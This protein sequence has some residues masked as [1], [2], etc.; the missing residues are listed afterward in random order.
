MRIALYSPLP[1]ERSGIADYSF[2]LLDELRHHVDV[3]AVVGDAQLASARAPEGV[4]LVPR[5][6]VDGLDIDCNLYQMGNNPRYHRSFWARAFDEPGLLVLHDPSLADITAEMCGGADG[7]IFRA[8]VAYD[9]PEIG[10]DDVLPLVETGGGRHDLDRLRVLLARRI[11]ESNIRTLVHSTAMAREMRHRYAGADIRTIQLPAPVLH[12]PSGGRPRAD[13]EIVFGVFG[14]INYYKRVRPLVDAFVEVRA[15]HPLARMVVAGRADEHLLERELRAIAARPELAGALE[16]KTD[17]TRE[18]LEREMLRCDV[19]ISLRWPTA[20]EM[21]ATLMRTLGAGRPAIVSD[22]LQFRELD[23]RYCWRVTTDF[24][25]EHEHLVSLMSAAATDLDRCRSAGDAAREFVAAE[26]TYEVVAGHYVEHLEHCASRRS[27]SRAEHR[28][29]SLSAGRPLGINVLCPVDRSEVA[30]AARRTTEVLRA[31]G[32]DVVVV[33][34]AS[35]TATTGVGHLASWRDVPTSAGSRAAARTRRGGAPLRSAHARTGA[36]PAAHDERMSA[37]RSAVRALDP[38]DL[39][40]EGSGPHRVDLLFVDPHDA[41]RYGRLAQVRRDRG[42][43]VVS[44]IA[45][46]CVGLPAAYE[47]VL[48]ISGRVLAPSVFAAD[49]ARLVTSVPVDV[50]PWLARPLRAETAPHGGPCTFLAIV[51]EGSPVARSNPRAAAAAFRQAFAPDERGAVARLVVALCGAGRRLEA[52]AELELELE[53]LRGELVV[54]PTS[55]ELDRLVAGTDVFVSLHRAEGFGLR[56]ADAMASGKPVL[57]TGWSGNLDYMSSEC[58]CLV[59]YEISPLVG[60]EMYADAYA[61]LSRDRGVFWVEPD[62]AGAARWMRRLARDQGER[63]RIGA[64]A[65]ARAGDMLGPATVGAALRAF[66][67]AADAEADAEARARTQRAVR[68]PPPPAARGAA[69]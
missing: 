23:E 50:V 15:R 11:V 31:V 68:W 64:A 30:E 47:D 58:A 28:A 61:D 65:A 43:H 67:V 5:S 35:P 57:A 26:A 66:A 52:H 32:V 62:V 27:S 40:I 17:L 69:Y 9:C 29:R 16:V 44:V 63:E 22:V 8:E 54:D 51:D 33:P 39:W 25:H 37:V 38:A 19:G 2:E 18:D 14:G 34:V 3:V 46:E 1:P 60:G 20:G 59:G 55:A 49:V 4:D 6:A 21:S 24:A 56:L 41:E 48:T 13:G 7:A 12:E 42:R 36:R 10:P 53:R 45:P